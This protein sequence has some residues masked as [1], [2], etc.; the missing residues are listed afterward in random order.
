MG[1]IV[2]FSLLSDWI[3]SCTVGVR[4]FVVWRRPKVSLIRSDKP[5][6]LKVTLNSVRD[7][8]T[9]LNNKLKLCSSNNPAPER[10]VFITPDF[11][12]LEQKKNKVLRQHEQD[13]EC[14][15]HK[16][17]KQEDSAEDTLSAFHTDNLLQL[18]YIIPLS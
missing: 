9:I 12:P 8:V 7:K 6:L 1:L 18:N 2:G 3:L 13:W 14:L 4:S 16:K 17:K 11:T 5:R 15:Y 10:N